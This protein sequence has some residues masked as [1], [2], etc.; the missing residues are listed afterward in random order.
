MASKEEFM[1]LKKTVQ[2]LRK[3]QLDVLIKLEA[4]AEPNLAVHGTRQC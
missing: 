3:T 1:Q 4:S 2:D